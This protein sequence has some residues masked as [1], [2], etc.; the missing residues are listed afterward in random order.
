[1][2]V[3]SRL[4]NVEKTLT[5][6]RTKRW[7]NIENTLTMHWKPVECALNKRWTQ[8][9]MNSTLIQRKLLAVVYVK[10]INASTFRKVKPSTFDKRWYMN[11]KL[12][13]PSTLS[14]RLTRMVMRWQNTMS[15]EWL[16][17]VCV[18]RCIQRSST[19]K[20]QLGL[21]KTGDKFTP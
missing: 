16:L 3:V 4:L 10:C 6:H 2:Y 19:K 7:L 9:N 5:K 11:A 1:M 21:I 8:R 20:C 13:Y 14:K 17:N 18:Q 12:R 15:R